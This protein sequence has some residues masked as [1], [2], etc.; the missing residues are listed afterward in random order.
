MSAAGGLV[1]GDKP[2]HYKRSFTEQVGGWT[3][4]LSPPENWPAKAMIV[5]GKSLSLVPIY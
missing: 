5:V 4:G 1:G 2:R 3:G